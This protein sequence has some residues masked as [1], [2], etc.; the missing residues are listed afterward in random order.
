MLIKP[1]GGTLI[2]IEKKSLEYDL[3]YIVDDRL[4]FDIEMLANG[5]FSPLTGFLNKED[6]ESVI[7][8]M[9]LKNGLI[10]SIPILFP[11]KNKVYKDNKILLKDKHN[12]NIGVFLVEDI[13]ELDLDNYVLKVFGTND[14][15]HPGVKV[16]FDGGN[17]FIGG[18]LLSYEYELKLEGIDKVLK[19]KETREIIEKNNWKTVVAFQT[20]NPI[21]RAHE[22]LIKVAQET[23]DSLFIHPLVGETKSDDIPAIVRVKCYEILVDK[24]FNKKRTLLS[25]LPAAMRYAGPREAIHHMIIRQNYGATH[26][27]IGRDHAGVGNYYGTYE[28]QELVEKYKDSL[29]IKSLN[30]EHSFYCKDCESIVSHKTCPH[31]IESH[32]ILSGT[33]VR[34]MLK[35]GER[36]PK[37]FSRPEVADILIESVQG[38][39]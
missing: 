18:K 31:S 36:P 2:S 15:N 12:N 26:M 34:E 37:E 21:H 28:A 24:Y 35:N 33:K 25:Y 17:Q 13:F 6:A 32:L 19:P 16:V 5:G 4:I 9:Y 39:K 7:N 11:F 22:Y 30:F 20:R 23:A 3:G 27:I 38:E 10:W 14:I 8:N 29:E 1:H